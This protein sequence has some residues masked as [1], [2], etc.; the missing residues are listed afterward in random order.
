MND[1][2]DNSLGCK[3]NHPFH[4]TVIFSSINDN[5]MEPE[6]GIF[7]Y[8]SSGEWRKISILPKI[9][10]FLKMQKGCIRFAVFGLFFI[11]RIKKGFETTILIP[12]FKKV[13][14]IRPKV[15]GT[16]RS[17]RKRRLERSEKFQG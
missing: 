11:V 5:G 13:N 17:P 9:K 14:V 8:N 2:A 12:H 16:G 4:N 1:L 3:G 15:P 6:G 10:F 7:T